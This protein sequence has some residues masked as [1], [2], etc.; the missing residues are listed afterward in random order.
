[1]T[2]FEN[3]YIS[4][5][6]PAGVQR[7]QDVAQVAK[8]T[9]VVIASDPLFTKFTGKSNQVVQLVSPCPCNFFGSRIRKCTCEV[10]SIEN[11]QNHLRQ[12]HK[13]CIWVDGQF[14]KRDIKYKDLDSSCQQLLKHAQQELK[15]SLGEL[16]TI[17]EIAEAVA[18]LDSTEIKPEHVAEA[19]S[20]RA[21]F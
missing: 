21:K 13:D 19:I 10:S 5:S 8:K 18:K 3:K 17:I 11:H 7:A 12:V 2:L 4:I 6:L 20:Y 9:L 16:V 1:M 15:F 14:S